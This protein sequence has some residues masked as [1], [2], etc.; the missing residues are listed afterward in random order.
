MPKT[1]N[2]S[3]ALSKAEREI[4]IYNSTRIMRDHMITIDERMDQLHDDIG[5]LVALQ[6]A[7]PEQRE[8][9]INKIREASEEVAEGGN[10][11]T[12]VQTEQNISN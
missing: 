6:V 4:V 1:K 7:S 11:E 2:K 9:L 5:L 12:E 8:D 3:R 10:N